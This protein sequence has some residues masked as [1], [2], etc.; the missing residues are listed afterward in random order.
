MFDDIDPRARALL[1]GLLIVSSLAAGPGQ[2]A[3]VRAQATSSAPEDRFA[4]EPKRPKAESPVRFSDSWDGARDEAKRTGRRLLA[5][6]TGK[7]CGWCRVLEKRTFTDA[8]VVELSKRFVCVEIDVG[9]GR[10]LRLADEY[11]IDTIPRSYVLNPEGQTIDRRTGYIPATEYAAWLKGVGTKPPAGIPAAA[12]SKPAAP[13]PV[14]NPEAEADVVIWFVDANRGIERWADDDWTGHAH[15]LRLLRAAGFRPRIEH[16]AR[17]DFPSRW[18]RA[19]VSRKLPELITA[20]NWAGLVRDLQKK[21]RLVTVRSDRLGWMTEIASCADFQGRWLYLVAGPPYQ[22]TG[23]RAVDELLRPGPETRLPGPELAEAAG[24]TEA[25]QVASS[26]AVAYISGDA[27]RLRSV[28]SASSPQLSRC[29]RPEELRRGWIVDTGEAEIRGNEAIAFARVEMHFRGK[30]MIGADPVAVVLRR[31]GTHWKAFSV[32]NDVLWVR[33]V[34]ELCRLEIRSTVGA[35][36]PP[37]PRLLH[38]DD[39]GPIGQAGRSFTWEIPAGGEP[40][41][42]Q[43][44]EVLLDQKGSSWPMSRIKVHPGEPRHRSLD[45]AATMQDV[46]GVTSDEMRWCVWAIGTDGLISASEARRYRPVPF[47]P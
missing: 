39:D 14:G 43:V 30:T 33:A 32:G 20:T 40:L 46:T 27:E 24:R 8:E 2:A 7:N 21:D 9:E 25:A 28:A 37:V 26:A 19:E 15:L 5:Y 29:T 3:P 17:E 41:A 1:R 44:C 13:R 4:D 47:K 12:G 23:R 34:P 35:Q 18:D 31:E 38:P 10:N 45:L 16:I 22:T 11:R 42:A 6:F 36:V